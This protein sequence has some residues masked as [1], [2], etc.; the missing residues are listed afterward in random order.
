[1]WIARVREVH[2]RLGPNDETGN[3]RSCFN[4]DWLLQTNAAPRQVPSNQFVHLRWV[5]SKLHWDV[6]LNSNDNLICCATTRLRNG[7]KL[8]QGDRYCHGDEHQSRHSDSQGACAPQTQNNRR[9][10]SYRRET[11]RVN[12]SPLRNLNQPRMKCLR[13]AER[14]P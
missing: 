3:L 13:V 10:C 9:V 6:G 1:M 2:R 12:T 8:R 5:A 14:I 11:N 7:S 4:R